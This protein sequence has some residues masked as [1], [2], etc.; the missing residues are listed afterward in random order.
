MPFL[1]QILHVLF[2][3]RVR[4]HRN[5]VCLFS[6]SCITDTGTHRG[7]LGGPLERP[8]GFARLQG[9][10][11]VAFRRAAQWRGPLGAPTV[12]SVM[13]AVPCP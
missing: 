4:V 13:R 5:G 10:P 2:H 11:Q 3:T 8:L 12:L 6:F 9:G 7:P 1:V